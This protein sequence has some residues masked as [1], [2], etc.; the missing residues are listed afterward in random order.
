MDESKDWNH[1]D[2][3]FI[4]DYKDYI[5]ST[6]GLLDV[7]KAYKIPVMDAQ[8]GSFSHKTGCPFR[9]HKR[10]REKTPSL[11]ID[12]I[13]NSFY[14]FGCNQFGNAMILVQRLCG[15]N[16]E[17]SHK[18]DAAGNESLKILARIGGLIDGTGNLKNIRN[19]V[20]EQEP[21]KETVDSVIF[22][23]NILLRDHLSGFRNTVKFESEAKWTDKMYL[24]LDQHFGKI[25]LYDIEKAEA[26]YNK[27]KEAVKTRND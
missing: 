2:N 16:F 14:C 26:I 27:L 9:L 24:K 13:N 25:D 6:V 5:L 17:P 12:S 15:Y 10:G 19:L 7:L 11:F 8:S 4:Y 3:Q 20:I 18:Q 1:I 23:C 22:N 21:Y